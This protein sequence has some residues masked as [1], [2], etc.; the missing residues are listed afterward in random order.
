[1][2]SAA[3]YEAPVEPTNYSGGLTVDELSVPG[4]CARLL[5]A[6]AH[7]LLVV[8][9][10]NGMHEQGMPDLYVL[11]E[12]GVWS[13]RPSVLQHWYDKAQKEWLQKVDSSDATDE[14]KQRVY[15]HVLLTCKPAG[16]QAA[17][18][19]LSATLGRLEAE[20]FGE[21]LESTDQVPVP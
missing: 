3:P 17:I 1:M 18:E 7:Q 4:D 5:L 19:Y 20:G 14:R 13:N 11:T 12:G 16:R 2:I 9:H 21:Q 6:C 15:K 10:V 8:S